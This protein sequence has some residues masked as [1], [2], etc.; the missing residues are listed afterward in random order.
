MVLHSHSSG[1]SVLGQDGRGQH[2]N[3][4][5]TLGLHFVAVGIFQVNIQGH[6]A[7]VL[8]FC[9]FQLISGS[10]RIVTGQQLGY[11]FGTLRDDTLVGFRSDIGHDCAVGILCGSFQ[12]NGSSSGALLLSGRG[13]IFGARGFAFRRSAFFFVASGDIFFRG[14]ILFGSILFLGRCIHIRRGICFRGCGILLSNRLTGFFLGDSLLFFGAFLRQRDRGRA[15]LVGGIVFRNV[16]TISRNLDTISGRGSGSIRVRTGHG[17]GQARHAHQTGQ[18]HDGQQN[19]D[20]S[21]EQV[22][23]HDLCLPTR[24]W[25]S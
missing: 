16:Y 9:F 21:A 8:Y 10:F 7:V 17:I 12:L 20:E 11:Q 24:I 6:I 3:A 2:D 25:Y 4:D 5:F 14:S 13:F 23:L 19:T 15:S 1:I 18:H 22:V